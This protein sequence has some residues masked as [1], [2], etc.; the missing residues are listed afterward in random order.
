[1][2]A[3]DVRAVSSHLGKTLVVRPREGSLYGPPV[4]A[5]EVE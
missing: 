4:I 1:M 5:D 3:G 2:L